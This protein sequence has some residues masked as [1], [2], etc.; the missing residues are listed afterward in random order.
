MLSQDKGVSAMDDEAR[1]KG[2]LIDELRQLRREIGALKSNAQEIPPSWKGQE[3]FAKAFLEN[4]T[5]VTIT[6]VNEGRF[7][8][9]SDAFLELT[10]LA[11]G[12]IIGQT[13]ADTGLITK[14]KRDE[15]LKELHHNKRVANVEM[16]VNTRMGLRHVLVNLSIINIGGQDCLLTVFTDIQ[17]RKEMEEKLRSSEKRFRTIYENT[18]LGIFETTPA[19]GV[20]HANRTFARMFGYASP[21][22]VIRT[23]TDLARQI[24]VD[25]GQRGEIIGKI[26]GSPTPQRFETAYR[27]KDGSI[28]KALL[29]IQAV[30]NAENNNYQF[31]GFVEDINERK[32]A[33]EGRRLA[34]VL[35]RTLAERS[36]AGVYVVQDSRFRFINSK[37]ALYAGY[38]KEELLG[39]PS[40]MMIHPE[41][42]ENAVNHAVEMLRGKRDMPYEFRIITKQGAT[43]WIMETVT[44]INYLGTPAILGNSMDVTEYKHIEA[45]REKLIFSLK[46]ALLEVKKL[47]GLLPICASCKKI[48]NDEGYWEQLEG[49][50]RDRWEAEFSHSMCHDC[51]TQWYPELFHEKKRR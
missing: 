15:L 43:R 11:K 25:P 39:Q 24:Y 10:G 42:R 30:W 9:V 12:E 34:E 37:A 44:S 8:D 32:K 48:R 29:E 21:E 17:R 26:M 23:L 18:A 3:I 20:L 41:D 47:S 40:D 13:S 36:F 51:V 35:Y 31:L 5:P 46:K 19:G 50:I 2:E 1:T 4:P 27:R 45:E 28:F 38:T 7:V 49:Y 33:E 16:R 14:E 6:T 22:E